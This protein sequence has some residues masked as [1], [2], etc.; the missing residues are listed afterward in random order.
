VPLLLA[1]EGGLS[2]TQVPVLVVTVFDAMEPV[3]LSAAGALAA[4]VVT[5]GL[6]DFCGDMGREAEFDRLT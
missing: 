3:T 6:S 4:L 1:Q 5:R 2:R